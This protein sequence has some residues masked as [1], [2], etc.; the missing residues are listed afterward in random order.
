MS[1]LTEYQISRI[2]NVNPLTLRKL[3]REGKIPFTAQQG[4]RPRFDVDAISAWLTKNPLIEDK[5]E[6]Y[7]NKIKSEWQ[8]KSPEVFA[9]LHDIDQKV[10]AHSSA[11][12]NPKRFNLIKRPNKKYGYLYYVRYIDNGKLIHSKWNT[13]TNIL[14]EAENFARQNRLKI[15]ANYYANHAIKN[16]ENE[17]YL[18]LGEYYKAGSSYLEKDKKRNRILGE[19]TRSVYYHFM[20]KKFIPYLQEN[21]IKTFGEINPSVI[22][23]F[24]DYLLACGKKPQTINRYLSSVNTAFDHLMIHGKIKDNVFDHVNA[25]KTGD[26]GIDVRDCFDVD[27][28]KGVFNVQWG[29]T[30][31]YLLCLII[32]STGIRNSEI[33]K[34]KVN[35]I[36]ELDGIHF[37]DIKI[38]KSKN[39]IRL[40]PLHGFVYRKIQQYIKQ[41][42][43]NGEDYIFSARGGPNQSTIYKQANLSLGGKV[44]ITPAELKKQKITFYSGRH[45]WKTLMNS[46]DLGEDIEEFFMGHKVS[47]DVAKNYNHKDKQ[48]KGKLTKKAKEAFAILDKKLFS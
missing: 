28:M 44:G 26:E 37:V 1:L 38:S 21:N 17:L 41:T 27:K 8:E 40:V 3:I 18:I 2:F 29:D 43:K 25:L 4:S 12:K 13:H 15:L 48:G 20:A 45:F 14:L 31:S 33:E 30:L 7:L 46:E 24:Q 23:N 16:A 34:I 10:I 22:A 11:Q 9:A 39:G 36:V 35:D 47:G 6:I 42:G 19:K 5:E 32:Y